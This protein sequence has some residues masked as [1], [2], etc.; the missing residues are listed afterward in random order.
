MEN[1]KRLYNFGPYS[2][3]EMEGVLLRDGCP[4]A[5]TPKAYDTLLI[6][7]RNNGHLVEKDELMRRL[8]P[9]TLVEEANVSQQIFTLRR[10]LGESEERSKYIETVPRRGYRFVAEVTEVLEPVSVLSSPKNDTR[11][12][13]NEGQREKL[14]YLAVLPFVNASGD[15]SMD[16]ISDG[17]TESIINSL[18][19]L[20]ML[21]VISRSTSFRYKG[22]D[23]D[24]QQIGRQLGVSAVLVGRVNAQDSRLLISAE[25]VDVDNGWQ[26][27]G[28]TYDRESGAILEIQSDISSQISATLR[29]R[30]T[31]EDKRRL[32][33]RFTEK[34]DAYQSYLQGRYHWSKYT[35]EGLQQA[36]GCFRQAIKLDPTY[37]L[38]YAGIIDCYLRL[39][40]NYLPPEDIL[41]HATLALRS[42]TKD[43]KLSERKTLP[44]SLKLR[45]EWDQRS[46]ERELRRASEMKSDYLSA[47]QWHAAYQFALRRFREA[48]WDWVQE[49][50]SP[51]TD[52]SDS[53]FE[54]KLAQQFESSLLTTA[55]EIQIYCAVAREQIDGGNYEAA[56]AVLERWWTFGEWPKLE[57]L[58]LDSS[59]DLLFTTGALA[60]C[61]A[62]T[63]QVPKGQKHAEALLNGSIALFEQLGSKTR[64]AEGR[65]ELGRCYYREGLFDLARDT[66]ESALYALPDKELE[67]RSIALA[68]LGVVGQ[69]SGHL[70]D[71]LA[72]LRKLGEIAELAGPAVTGRYHLEIATALK[73]LA[74]AEGSYDDFELPLKHYAE[75]LYEFEAT[76]NHRFAAIA[77]NNHGYLLLTLNRLEG[78]EVHLERARRL[79]N[80]FADQVGGAQVAETLAQ[81]YLAKGNLE[82]AESS[83]K[84]SVE[85]L[86]TGGEEVLLSESLKTQGLVLCRLGRYDEAKRVFLRASQVAE[87]C[88][89]GESAGQPLLI[90][91][92][93]MPEHLSD[94]E[95]VEL[96]GKLN[97]LLTN[98]QRTSIRARLKKCREL[99]G[100][101]HTNSVGLK[102][103]KV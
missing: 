87:R 58:N 93:E 72:Q 6:L 101:W 34:P 36:I 65:I 22:A 78:A 47:H 74:I 50:N 83:I 20:A 88:G 68:R 90:M 77:E 8:W 31:G 56:C 23:F 43:E 15:V 95:R 94:N 82:L 96:V 60:G 42:S 85:V 2:L 37:A 51:A 81:L 70:Y 64:A 35:R 32:S 39:A 19:Q 45:Y 76:G 66:F 63:R 13:I 49:F 5:L 71:A 7:V 52:S 18:S 3:N 54:A 21:R 38:A 29:L 79:F 24:A 97:D 89:D 11:Q 86:Q 12:I 17:I 84:L 103:P 91:I 14:S 9:E 75:A 4:V 25:L 62:S 53:A 92:E 69:H 33:K 26:L 48:G 44:D 27:W 40:T 41:P 102:D 10:T 98:S 28:E 67:L 16:Y 1:A 73:D 55:E 100:H 59:A 61:V 30:L 99:V 57:G 80:S 46:V